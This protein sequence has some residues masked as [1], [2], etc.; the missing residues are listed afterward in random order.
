MLIQRC[1][2]T[3]PL[4][5]DIDEEDRRVETERVLEQNSGVTLGRV[6]GAG[7]YI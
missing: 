7:P 1:G 6:T 4:Y 2:R 3:R 5:E